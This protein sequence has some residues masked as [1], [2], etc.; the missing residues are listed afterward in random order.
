[1][2]GEAEPES[3]IVEPAAYY[4]E[5]DV[6]LRLETRVASLDVGAR[7]LG[8][9]G[10]ER[11]GFERLV[12]ATGAWPRR[13]DVPGADLDGVYTL[14]TMDNAR[15]IRQR[16]ESAKA[17]VIVGTGFIGPGSAGLIVGTP[18]WPSSK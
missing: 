15:T 13:L 12:I 2:R 14:R 3:S 1:M 9:E 11:L 8:I 7:E 18:S 16:A 17:A 6:R 4:A 10:G 5:H